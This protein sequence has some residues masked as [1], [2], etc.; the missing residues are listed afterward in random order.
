SGPRRSESAATAGMLP[1]REDI[2]RFIADAQHKV[3][4]REIARAFGIKGGTRIVLKQLLAE[5]AAEGLITGNRSELRRK[6]GL[7]P[8][9]VLEITGREDDGDLIARPVVWN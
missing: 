3:G 8:I 5:M 2:L 1:S 9:T 7:P 4:K 6:G